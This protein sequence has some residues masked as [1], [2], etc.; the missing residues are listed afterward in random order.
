MQTVDSAKLAQAKFSF[1]QG[2]EFSVLLLE[3][4]LLLSKWRGTR[5]KGNADRF[6]RNTC[7]CFESNSTSQQ[8]IINI[9]S[10]FRSCQPCRNLC[11]NSQDH[12]CEGYIILHFDISHCDMQEEKLK[13]V[14]VL[15]RQTQ[16][17]YSTN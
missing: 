11:A 2:F 17:L 15:L 3:I 1:N 5:K 10:I 14:N 9:S 13:K 6:K 4:T 16:L 7:V 8:W 12:L